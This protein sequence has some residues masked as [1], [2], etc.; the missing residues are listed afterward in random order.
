VKKSSH[1]GRIA[2]GAWRLICHGNFEMSIVIQSGNV[3]S[4]KER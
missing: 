4:E 2:N 1:T 3:F